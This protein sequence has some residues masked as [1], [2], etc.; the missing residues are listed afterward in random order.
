MVFAGMTS[1]AGGR[2]ASSPSRLML[3]DIV[4]QLK[5]ARQKVL[6]GDYE[7][8]ETIYSFVIT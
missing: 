8:A 2:E 7:E 3:A 1:A 6:Y 5:E 4:A